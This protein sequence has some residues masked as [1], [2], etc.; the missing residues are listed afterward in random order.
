MKEKKLIRHQRWVDYKKTSEEREFYSIKRID[1]LIISISGACIYIMFEIFKFI[2]SPENEILANTLILKMVG[3]F[4]SIAIMLNFFSQFTGYHANKKESEYSNERI[5]EIENSK[6]NSKAMN[7]IDKKVN[8][9]NKL[10]DLFNKLSALAMIVS[11]ILLVIF[12][13]I[14]F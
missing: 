3:C 9:Y 13:L 12:G 14:T 1:I 6:N 8:L 10:T 5:D 11:V 7:E 2:N 4:A